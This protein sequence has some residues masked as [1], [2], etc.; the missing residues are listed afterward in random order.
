MLN[1]EYSGRG[2]QD[3]RKRCNKQLIVEVMRIHWTLHQ[4][5]L[6]NDAVSNNEAFATIHEGVTCSRNLGNCEEEFTR[7][8]PGN[9]N[10]IDCSKFN[11]EIEDILLAKETQVSKEIPP[12]E[13][14]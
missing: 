6:H 2:R 7:S 10:H 14:E 1:E 4:H 12:N 3:E 11:Q 13:K 8:W 9:I 5:R